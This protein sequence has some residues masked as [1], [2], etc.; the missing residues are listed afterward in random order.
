[1]TAAMKWMRKVRITD[2]TG[3]REDKHTR[4]DTI[5][6]NAQ[7]YYSY[8]QWNTRLCWRRNEHVRALLYVFI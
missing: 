7:V 8:K 1:M 5:T 6:H 3:D 2:T 4:S